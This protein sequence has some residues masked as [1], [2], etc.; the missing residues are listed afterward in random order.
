MKHLL[1]INELQVGFKTYGGEVKAVRG[2]SFYVDKGEVVAI[3]GESGCGKSVTAQAIMGMVKEGNGIRTEGSIRFAGQ[4]MTGLSKKALQEIR[5]SKIGMVFQDPMTSLNPTMKIGKQI[6][7]GLVKHQGL[8]LQEAQQKTIDLLRQVGIP[9][10]EKRY[11]Q[12][13][14]EFSG[15][16]RQRVVIAIAIACSPQLLIADEPTTALDVTIQ[17][18]ILD[19]LLE[20]QQKTNTSIIM[21]THDLGVVS[22]MA[23]RVVVMY[24]GKIVETGT[25]E[26]LFESPS[27]PYTKGLLDSVPKLDRA[28]KHRLVPIDGAPPD[29]FAPPKGCP[30]APRCPYAMEI[31]VDHLP[32]TTS[33]SSTHQAS[34]WLHDPRSLRQQEFRAAGR[35]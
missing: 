28:G 23:Q 9:E 15:G 22:E 19:L 29:L 24:A 5:G 21:I 33:F 17:A 1:E 6:A 20:L 3:V 25:A 12:Y 31:C 35:A 34:C 14:H 18:Q 2:I 27:H 8:S 7:E 13:P 10:A 26:E 30:F 11:H 4:E 32:Q 16:M